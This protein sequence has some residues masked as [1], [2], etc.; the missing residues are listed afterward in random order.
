MFGGD[1]DSLTVE[2]DDGKG[3]S[4]LTAIV[5]QQQTSDAA[6]WIP[7]N[8]SLSAYS[9]STVQIRFQTERLGFEGDIAIDDFQRSKY[10]GLSATVQSM[11][12]HEQF[13]H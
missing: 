8:L 13:E 3:Y 10:R 9:G 6:A 4:F 7:V 2:V 12:L 1:I 11:Y 5:G